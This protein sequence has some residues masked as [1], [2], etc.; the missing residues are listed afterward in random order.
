MKHLLIALM[1]FTSTAYSCDDDNKAELKELQ[2][3]VERNNQLQMM[4]YQQ[5]ILNPPPIIY[6]PRRADGTCAQFPCLPRR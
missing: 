1:L 5:Q 2:E 6:Q 3:Q 4:N